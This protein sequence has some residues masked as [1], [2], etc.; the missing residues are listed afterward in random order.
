MRPQSGLMVLPATQS[1]VR[2][3]HLFVCTVRDGLA[4]L[5][6]LGCPRLLTMRLLAARLGKSYAA[7]EAR[8]PNLDKSAATSPAGFAALKRNPCTSLQPSLRSQSS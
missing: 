1:V 8:R 2:R 4:K 3:R 7:C 5:G 6:L